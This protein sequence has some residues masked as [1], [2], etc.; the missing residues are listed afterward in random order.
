MTRETAKTYIMMELHSQPPK[1]KKIKPQV[2]RRLKG[3][4]DAEFDYYIKAANTKEPLPQY[5]KP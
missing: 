2:T 3:M 1:K 5:L 4:T